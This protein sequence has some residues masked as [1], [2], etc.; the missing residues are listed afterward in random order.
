MVTNRLVKLLLVLVLLNQTVWAAGLTYYP[1]K[2]DSIFLD[3]GV[4]DQNLIIA[5]RKLL[6]KKHLRQSAG[7]PD[8]LVDSCSGHYGSCYSQ[9]TLG[10]RAARRHLFGR[11]HLRE[12]SSG[13]Y[14]RDVYCNKIFTNNYEKQDQSAVKRQS[15]KRRGI[16]IGPM[17]IPNNNVLN[18]EHIWP[19]S[20]FSRSYSKA[21]QKTDLHHLFPTDS[22]ANSARG[23]FKFAEVD[24]DAVYPGCDASKRGVAIT[25]NKSTILKS[26]MYFEPDHQFKGNVARAVFYFSV[27]YNLQLSSTEEFYLKKW[28]REDPV[29]DEEVIRNGMIQEL[30]NNRNPFIDYPGLVRRI[31]DF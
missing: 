22:K 14:I 26:Y 17:S 28:H 15:W 11:L 29:D 1:E 8:I 4:V 12:N 20:R 31:S 2:T 23:S 9:D 21:T 16:N 5:I 13:Y 27:R 7:A 18:C 6:T 19:Q 24:G 3:G 10:Y 30:Q 25:P